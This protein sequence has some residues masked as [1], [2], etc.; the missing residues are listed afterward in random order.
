MSVYLVFNGI[1]TKIGVA[2]NV[3]KRIRELQTASH[4]E[5][6]LIGSIPNGSFKLEKALHKKFSK[7]R[8]KGEWFKLSF[9][10][11]IK[12]K[13]LVLDISY[14]SLSN[15]FSLKS[16]CIMNKKPNSKSK[17]VPSL[18]SQREVVSTTNEV[19]L[20][21]YN[22]YISI[23]MVPHFNLLD[24][25]VVGKS[26][27]WTARKVKDNRLKLTKAGHIYFHQKRNSG[28]LHSVWV[29]GKEEIENYKLLAK[30]ISIVEYVNETESGIV[31]SVV[32]G[33]I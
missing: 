10:Q 13:D 9:E 18:A 26:I 33:E 12:I 11:I 22:Y 8:L 27:G 30:D 32:E 16:N 19:V 3:H 25:S 31:A 21:L 20:Y 1:A 17:Y 24:D 2:T 7:Y 4:E 29:F 5:L 28:V 15:L 6:V 14:D 23:A